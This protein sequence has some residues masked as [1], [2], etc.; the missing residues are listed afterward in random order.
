MKVSKSAIPDSKM[1]ES[2]SMDEA[3]VQRWRIVPLVL[4]PCRKAVSRIY[5]EY[6]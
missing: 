1:I 5:I 6:G 2:A 4:A 3:L